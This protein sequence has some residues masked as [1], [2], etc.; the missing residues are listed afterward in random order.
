VNHRRSY[1][2]LPSNT[3]DQDKMIIATAIAKYDDGF[4]KLA[5]IFMAKLVC[6]Y[7]LQKK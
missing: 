5:R 6:K 4:L 3:N 7:F 1:Q 2:T